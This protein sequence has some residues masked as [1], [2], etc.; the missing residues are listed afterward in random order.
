MDISGR[1]KVFG[2]FGHPI[3]HSLSPAMHNAAIQALGLDYVYVPFDVDPRDLG[4]AVDGVRALGIAG[5]NVTIPHKEAVIEFLDEVT[6]DALEIGSVNTIANVG[7]RLI[8]SST[9]G[10]A[11]LRSLVETGYD[12]KGS[13]AVLVGG[14]GA[15]RAV[16]FALV[17]SGARVVVI[18]E[19]PGKA[20]RL[21]A[22]VRNVAGADA[23]KGE[24]DLASVGGHLSDA[25]LLVNCTPVGMYPNVDRMP[26]S[27]DLLREDV[28]VYDV[29]YNPL[30][31]K[32][33]QCAE[34]KGARAV[35]GIKMFVY[36]GAISFKTWTGIDPPADNMEAAV[37]KGP[38]GG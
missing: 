27:E 18:D 15:G 3:G 16:A 22:D 1:A 4:K 8:G 21:A 17:K 32:L 12:P 2:V 13:K 7:G 10:P 6:Q 23:A 25:N 9:D 20:E 19:A 38:R 5:V 30:R 37:I 31:T 35:S 26:I 33:L 29:V 28:T 14:G 36:Q 24:S 11:F 34:R